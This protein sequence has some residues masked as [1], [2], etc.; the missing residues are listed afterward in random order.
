LEASKIAPV[1]A[2]GGAQLLKLGVER[3]PVGADVGIAEAAVFQFGFGH[4]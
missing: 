4:L 1:V 3:L 2:S